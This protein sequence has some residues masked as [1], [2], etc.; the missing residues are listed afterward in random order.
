M[1]LMTKLGFFSVVENRDDSDGLIVRARCEQDIVNISHV[2]DKPLDWWLDE[3]ADYGYRLLC[4]KKEWADA[5]AAMA[6][7]IDY[8]NFKSSVKD[9]RHHSAYQRVWIDMLYIDDRVID[10]TTWGDM[11]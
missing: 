9:E 4:S 10:D 2:L 11:L 3:K 7:D 1:W 6:N 8:D 5:L